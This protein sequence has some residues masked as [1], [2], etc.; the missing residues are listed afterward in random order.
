MSTDFA[1]LEQVVKLQPVGTW[2]VMDESSLADST[3]L[4]FFGVIQDILDRVL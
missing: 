1:F 4:G 3:S 2:E